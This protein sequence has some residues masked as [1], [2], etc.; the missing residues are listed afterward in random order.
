[1]KGGF[2][3]NVCENYFNNNASSL[4]RSTGRG[5]G[6]QVLA[7][8]VEKCCDYV[9]TRCVIDLVFSY[10]C[11]PLS[12]FFIMIS[13]RRLDMSTGEYRKCE[14]VMSMPDQFARK[15]IGTEVFL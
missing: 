2:E 9:H 6:N 12:L 1:M 4:P 8:I 15:W 13:R 3:R 10:I 5:L 14:L 11:T 7:Y